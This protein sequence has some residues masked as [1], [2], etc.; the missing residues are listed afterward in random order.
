MAISTSLIRALDIMSVLTGHPSGIT[1]KE[2]VEA[3]AQPRS[4]VVRII[5][6]LHQYGLI[7]RTG[8]RRLVASKSFHDLCSPDRYSHLRM[9]YRPL[10]NF[11]AEQLDELVL[12][13]VQE[14]NAIIHIDYIESDQRIRVAP[15][16]TTRHDLSQNAIGKI[17]LSRRPDLLEEMA[18]DRL[19]QE[20]IA[21]RRTGFAWN[22]EETTPGMIAMASAGF[23]NAPT[24]PI[25]A[26]AWPSFRFSELKASEAQA[27][28]KDGLK[29]FHP[30]GR[31]IQAFGMHAERPLRHPS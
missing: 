17:A 15:S 10:L 21:V 2:I 31:T 29:K 3:L 13:G 18:D 8:G 16:P 9:K 27:T 26:V 23:T 25:I 12:L 20:L 24:E 19:R 11:I 30:D 5:N 7:E 22:R 6:T 28:I 4:N 1:I 14:G